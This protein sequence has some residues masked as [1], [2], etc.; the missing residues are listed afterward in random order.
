MRIEH[1]GAA[2][3]RKLQAN[4]AVHRKSRYS[5]ADIQAALDAV[6][7]N[8]C[9]AAK[10]IGGL[11]CAGG[12]RS[13]IGRYIQRLKFGEEQRATHCRVW[14]DDDIE[15]LKVEWN[16]DPDDEVNPRMTTREIAVMFGTTSPAL[17]AVVT[18]Y[19]I[20]NHAGKKRNCRMC[21]L[22]FWS[23]GIDNWI[24]VRCKTTDLYRCST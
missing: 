21:E 16:R 14:T 17:S 18:R 9:Q 15:K 23:D 10:L 13:A 12:A 24:C 20:A 8:Q 22:P 11:G 5:D 7:G 6:G 1:D 19:G 2:I 4:G 3:S